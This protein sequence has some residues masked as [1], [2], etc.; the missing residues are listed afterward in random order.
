MTTEGQDDLAAVLADAWARLGR[1]TGERR[2]TTGRSPS[3]R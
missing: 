1:A 3:P 2:R